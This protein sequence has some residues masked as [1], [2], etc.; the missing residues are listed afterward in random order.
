MTKKSGWCPDEHRERINRLLD[1]G[2]FNLRNYDFIEAGHGRQC[3]LAQLAE[4]LAQKYL[5]MGEAHHPPVPAEII[6]LLDQQHAVEVRQLPLKVYHGAIWSH[7]DEWVIQ[8]KDN[9]AFT[10]KRFTLFH[11]AFHILAHCRSSPVFRKR[12]S[13][14]G[15]FNELLAD[16]FALCTLMPREWVKEW[17]ARVEDLDRVAEIFAVPKSAM[18]IRLRQL[19]L[20]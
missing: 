15:S 2:Q 11:E 14:V 8:I 7:N 16:Y 17:W 18:C 1:E 9:D 5:K 10:T 6:K 3:R 19:G 12:G 20:I 4:T 13:V